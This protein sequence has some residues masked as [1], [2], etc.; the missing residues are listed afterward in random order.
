MKLLSL[1]HRVR[2]IKNGL[3]TSRLRSAGNISLIATVPRPRSAPAS[4]NAPRK[5][6]HRRCLP[7][8]ISKQRLGVFSRTQS[9]WSP[10]LAKVRATEVRPP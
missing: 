9:L 1:R 3:P 4:P 5:S 10:C 6:R 2:K 8:L 7:C